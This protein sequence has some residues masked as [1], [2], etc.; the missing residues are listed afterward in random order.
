MKK[1]TTFIASIFFVFSLFS[2]TPGKNNFDLHKIKYDKVIM[3]GDEALS[4]LMVNPNPSTY[5]V[6]NS[7]SKSAMTLE[8]IGYTTYDIQ[9]NGSIQNRIIVHGDGTISEGTMLKILVAREQ[10]GKIVPS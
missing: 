2:Q 10:F 8:V 4:H 6:L 7:N 1:T 5:P 9:T 3:K